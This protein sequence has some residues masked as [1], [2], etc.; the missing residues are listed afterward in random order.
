MGLSG[1][2]EF[3]RESLPRERASRNGESLCSLLPLKAK[4]PR[5][6]ISS[7]CTVLYFF[8]LKAIYLCDKSIY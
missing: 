2:P 7:V 3:G 4:K 5:A 1:V 8:I 6:A